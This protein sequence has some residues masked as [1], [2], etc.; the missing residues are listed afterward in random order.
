MDDIS[1]LFRLSANGNDDKLI[2][3]NVKFDIGVDRNEPYHDQVSFSALQF[4][5][6]IKK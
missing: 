1:S 2:K 5:Y 6:K 4:T 3:K